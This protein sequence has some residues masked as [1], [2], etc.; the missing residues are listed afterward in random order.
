M[1]TGLYGRSRDRSGEIRRKNGNTRVDTLREEY[2]SSFGREVRGDAKLETLL[3]R[4]RR[5]SLTDYLRH[6]RRGR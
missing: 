5:R 2:G 1:S 3:E 6:Q 4:S